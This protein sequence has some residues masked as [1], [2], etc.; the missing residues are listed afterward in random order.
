MV[1]AADGPIRPVHHACTAVYPLL[2]CMT[3]IRRAS[4]RRATIKRRQRKH[5]PL[6]VAPWRPNLRGRKRWR[7]RGGAEPLPRTQPKAPPSDAP[8]RAQDHASS[9]FLPWR[10]AS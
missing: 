10:A 9:F 4:G 1:Q 3:H 2:N 7:G 6:S 8:G 5:A